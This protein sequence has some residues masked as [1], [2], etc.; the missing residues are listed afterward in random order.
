M[1]PNSGFAV[2]TLRMGAKI[3]SAFESG[4]GDDS[5]DA[6]DPPHEDSAKIPASYAGPSA[7]AP[8]IKIEGKS[9]FHPVSMEAR[10]IELSR[11]VEYYTQ[12]FQVFSRV[13]GELHGSL[14]ATVRGPNGIVAL[15]NLLQPFGFRVGFENGNTLVI[16]AS[17]PVAKRDDTAKYGMQ[18]LSVQDENR[19]SDA[20]PAM[21][22]THPIALVSYASVADRPVAAPESPNREDR[23]RPLVKQVKQVKQVAPHEQHPPR[24]TTTAADNPVVERSSSASIDELVARVIESPSDPAALVALADAYLAKRDRAAAMKAAEQALGLNRNSPDANAVMGRVL[25]EAGQ[26]NR[27]RHY[28]EQA[29]HLTRKPAP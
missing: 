29:R 22:T 4:T 17:Q 25:L 11:M 6:G 12:H 18:V 7:Y 9:L 26:E 27:G 13:Q 24:P 19:D 3:T 28:L 21:A 15:T 16:D 2:A 20:P 23:P 14:S 8:Y 5:A 10:N 1:D